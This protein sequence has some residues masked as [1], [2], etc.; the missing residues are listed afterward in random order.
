MGDLTPEP[1]AGLGPRDETGGGLTVPLKPAEVEQARSMTWSAPVSGT[2]SSN[3][4]TSCRLPGEASMNVGMLPRRSS[5]ACNFTAASARWKRARGKT[6]RPG[7]MV[8]KSSAQAVLSRS[9]PKSPSACLSRAVRITHWAKS[10]WCASRVSR[11]PW[12]ASWATPARGN[13]C[14]RASGTGRAG[15][16]RCRAGSPRPSAVRT[17]CCGTCRESRPR[18]DGTECPSACARAKS[19][20]SWP[21]NKFASGHAHHYQL[22]VNDIW[23]CPVQVTSDLSGSACPFRA[24][25]CNGRRMGVPQGFSSLPVGDPIV[26]AGTE[27]LEASGRAGSTPRPQPR[28]ATHRACPSMASAEGTG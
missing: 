26:V 19:R 14:D 18:T 16:S 5:K 17:T 2:R 4:L 15:R 13:P 22:G 3:T 6:D 21:W 20:G 24:R 23:K 9:I 7:S 27:R 8:V 10:A 28:G 11:W 25:P 1:E 12:A